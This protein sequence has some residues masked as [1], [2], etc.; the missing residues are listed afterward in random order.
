ML[1]RPHKI[2][3]LVNKQQTFS[4]VLE[5]LLEKE[6]VKIVYT[7]ALAEIVV[8]VLKSVTLKEYKI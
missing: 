6:T 7:M 5:S 3:F 8:V 4:F 1:I 2:C